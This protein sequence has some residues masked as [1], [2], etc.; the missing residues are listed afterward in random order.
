L[1]EFVYSYD[2]F[3]NLAAR[4]DSINNVEE[5]FTYDNY[6]QDPT[7]QQGFNR[8]A[9]CGYNPLKYTDPTG[10]RRCGLSEAEIMY[11][12]EQMAKQNA[13]REWGIICMGNDV[14][15]KSTVNGALSI[16]TWGDNKTGGGHDYSGTG[17][18]KKGGFNLSK[19]TDSQRKAFVDANNHFCTSSKL[20][21]T[22][23]NAV[24]NCGKDIYIEIDENL[25]CPGIF[26][27]K[28][29][30]IKY[31][32]VTD[33]V[34]FYTGTE[35]IIHAYQ[36]AVNGCLYSD[37]LDFNY[38]FEAKTIK[39][40]VAMD[41]PGLFGAT[42]DMEAM[43]NYLLDCEL[44]NM[45]NNSADVFLNNYMRMAYDFMIYHINAMDKS[46]RMPTY[47]NPQSII[48]LKLFDLW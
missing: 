40:C 8:Y 4:K 18:G 38:E 17:N 27:D 15:H 36:K 9:Y 16:Y 23:F 33:M 28:N 43:N 46:Y 45:S 44:G 24:N 20:Y 41:I 14:K 35:E 10:E 34:D 22:I 1:R 21:N 47:Q 32:S 39:A 48:E 13:W 5:T 6:V 29:N 31:R 19:L 7:S 30:T 37:D 25:E 26:D 3:G 2:K 12:D 11:L 42:P